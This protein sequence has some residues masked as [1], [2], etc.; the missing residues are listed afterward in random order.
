VSG[1]GQTLFAFVRHWSRR[2]NGE[3]ADRGRLVLVTEAAH[4]LGGGV[5]IN[6]LAD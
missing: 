5:T 1:P 3:R 4:S 2:W 6:A